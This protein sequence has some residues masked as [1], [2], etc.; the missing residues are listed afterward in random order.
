VPSRSRTIQTRSKRPNR[1]W[2]GFA[3]AV[4]TN[5]GPGQKILIGNFV[6]SNSNIDETFLRTVG[7]LGVQSD[8]VASNEQQFGALGIIAVSDL[9]IAAG[10]A[11]I[12]G[13]IT[14]RSDDGWMLYVPFVQTFQVVSASGFDSNH[15]TQYPFDSKAKRRYE[16]GMSAAIMVENSHASHAFQIAL[17]FRSL[18]MISGTG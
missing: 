2:A 8:Q 4:V 3:S 18:S 5:V 11:S 10:A 15:M 14:D 1:S 6:L 13:P 12:P 7:V 9:A 17:I 16:E